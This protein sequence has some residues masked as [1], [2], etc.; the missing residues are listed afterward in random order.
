[1]LLF[2]QVTRSVDK[3][4]RM[5]CAHARCMIRF[6]DGDCHGDYGGHEDAGSDDDDDDDNDDDDDDDERAT[7]DV[8]VELS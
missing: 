6:D 8:V 7:T 1:M 5:T 4:D 3:I 2:K